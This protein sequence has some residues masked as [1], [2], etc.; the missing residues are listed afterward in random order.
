V[1]GSNPKGT[2]GSANTGGQMAVPLYGAVFPTGGTNAGVGGAQAMYGA[3][4]P[5][6]NTGG[7]MAVPAYG[8]SPIPATGGTSNV[9]GTSGTGGIMA[10]PLYGASPIPTAKP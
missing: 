2:G 6:Q 5:P 3:P 7:Q 8:I 10:Q 4:P 1:D 9:G